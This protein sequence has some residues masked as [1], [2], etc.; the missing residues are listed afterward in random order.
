MENTIISSADPTQQIMDD[1]QICGEKFN[2]IKK[3]TECVKCNFVCCKHC[4][5]QYIL[6]RVDEP[7]CMNCKTQ[8]SE[9][10]LYENVNKTFMN[11]TY[12][13][14]KKEILFDIEKSRIPETMPNVEDYKERKRLTDENCEIQKEI[15]ELK[16]RLH[17][18]EHKKVQNT[19]RIYL[20]QSGQGNKNSEKRKFNHKCP[21]EDCKGFLSTA[22]KCGVCNTWTCPKC[23]EIIGLNKDVEHTCKK[24][25]IESAELIKKETKPCPQCAIPIFKISGCDQMW[26]TQCN[27]AFSWNTGKVVVGGT[28]HNP[29]YFQFLRNGGVI[30]NQRNPGDVVCGGIP[31]VWELSRRRRELQNIFSKINHQLQTSEDVFINPS[32][33]NDDI[34]KVKKDIYKF[35]SPRKNKHPE[36]GVTKNAGPLFIKPLEEF[37]NYLR[38]LGHNR[39][40]IANMRERIGYNNNNLYDRIKYIVGEMSEDAF[41]KKIITKS[42]KVQKEQRVLQVLEILEAVTIENFNE[43][44]LAMDQF[45]NKAKPIYNIEYSDEI[46]V[47]P[48]VDFKDMITFL[49]TFNSCFDRCEK[50]ADYCREQINIVRKNYNSTAYKVSPYFVVG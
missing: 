7:H 4:V 46:I 5:Q 30:Q 6:S 50:V 29:H 22:W 13:N 40:V 33:T 8:F 37:D 24:E 17:I 23:F 12:R 9:E 20:I 34:T 49:N 38:C 1:C 26:C 39:D 10:F 14:H 2:K 42:R 28:I 16:S 15:N 45:W 48:P 27:I 31:R 47:P 11:Q 3:Q 32:I 18:L 44:K 19:N 25:N 35:I 43:I 36:A 41:K 21:V